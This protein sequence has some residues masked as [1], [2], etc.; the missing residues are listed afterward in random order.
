[1]KM[2]TAVL[3]AILLPAPAMALELFGVTLESTTRDELSE[4]VRQA[5]VELLREGGET[6]NFD[7]YDSSAVMPG[8]SRLY[9]GFEP[10]DQRF[11]FAEY[12]FVGTDT[13]RLLTELARKYGSPEVDP[14]RFLSDHGYRWQRDG[15]EIRLQS[16]WANYRTRLSYAEP[17]ALAALRAGPAVTAENDQADASIS[18][19]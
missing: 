3:L 11:A 12:E 9:L 4:A 14:G 10:L 6:S 18:F 8:S 7:V 15:I 19:F 1:M 5:G 2:N 17:A 16:D 13:R